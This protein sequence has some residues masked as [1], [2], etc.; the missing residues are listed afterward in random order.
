MTPLMVT[1]T[2]DLPGMAIT[3]PVCACAGARQRGG[4]N[5]GDE[6][7]SAHEMPVH[8]RK[9]DFLNNESADGKR[10]TRG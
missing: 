4:A 8:F 3:G 9:F 1:G 2:P 7:T 10:L 5:S 6:Q